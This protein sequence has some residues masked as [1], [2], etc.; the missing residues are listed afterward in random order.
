MYTKEYRIEFCMYVKPD[1]KPMISASNATLKEDYNYLLLQIRES[2]NL[3]NTNF[4][5]VSSKKT[6]YCLYSGQLFFLSNIAAVAS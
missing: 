1:S 5:G 2:Q 3:E 4:S 6:L